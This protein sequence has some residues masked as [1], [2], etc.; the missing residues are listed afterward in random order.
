MSLYPEYSLP[1]PPNDPVSSLTFNP[2]PAKANELLVA[3]WDKTVRFYRLVKSDEAASSSSEQLTSQV[4]L[5]HTFQHEAAVLDVCWIS[6]TLAASGGLDRRVRLLNLE[7][8]QSNIIGKHNAAIS[9]VKYSSTSNLLLSSSWDSS[10]KVWDPLIPS[11]TLLRTISLPDKVLAMD[12]SPPFPHTSL[13]DQSSVSIIDPT[14][15]AVVGMAGRH[16]HIYNLAKWREEVDR[17]KAGGQEDEQVWNAEQKRESSLKFMVRDIRC[18]PSGDGYA[19]SSVEGRIAVEF[20]DTSSESQAKKY[21]FKCH[22]QIID[23]IDTVYPVN[24]MAF[25]PVHA[26][27]ASLGGDAIISIWDPLAKKRIRQ[28]PKMVSPLSSGAISSD[29]ATLATASGFENIEDTRHSGESPGEVG[30][31]GKGGVGNVAIHIRY[32]WEDCKPKSKGAA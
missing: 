21:A 29:G 9:R 23:G 28:Y 5:V 10:L 16:I 30:E 12:L 22:R 1:D 15:R 2:N 19:T 3:S 25:H 14:P 6:D 24:A 31:L 32:A 11:P 7:T 27:F 17:V 18:M 8:G 4:Q 13:P 26:T 20:F